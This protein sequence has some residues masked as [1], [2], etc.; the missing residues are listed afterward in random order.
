[1]I[2]SHVPPQV[3]GTSLD[4]LLF[5]K[6]WCKDVAVV[7]VILLQK[8]VLQPMGET[9]K[10]QIGQRMGSLKTASS[11]VKKP[12]LVLALSHSTRRGQK[13]AVLAICNHLQMSD[14]LPCA[15]GEWCI[16]HTQQCPACTQSHA[17][18]W[19]W[20]ILTSRHPSW[21]A[22]VSGGTRNIQANKQGKREESRG[23]SQSNQLP[24]PEAEE[25]SQAAHTQK[26]RRMNCHVKYMFL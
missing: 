23:W 5:L 19:Q 11:G 12:M 7:G 26:S 13:G 9:R 18:V 25:E 2:R 10:L 1:M 17:V 16:P 8:S 14:W 3:V 24:P 4:L 15:R 6:M 20:I 22:E 21:A